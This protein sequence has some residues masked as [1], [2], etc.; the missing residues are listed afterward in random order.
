MTPIDRLRD[1]AALPSEVPD[2]L[3]SAHL[4]AA[5]RFM[6]GRLMIAAA[7]SGFEPVWAEAATV[8]ALA[9]AL[10]WLNTFALSGAAKVGRLDGNVE[11][12]FLTPDEVEAREKRLLARFDELIAS[13]QIATAPD[14]PTYSVS[15][16]DLTLTAI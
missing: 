13:L 7:P 14:E 4:D 1:Y 16:P 15:S 2:S 3:L 10:P 8:K 12:R 6:R 9:S 5:E 11:F